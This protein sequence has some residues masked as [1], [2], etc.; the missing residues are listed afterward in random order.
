MHVT[1]NMYE[2]HWTNS[3]CV[4]GP[5]N[6]TFLTVNTLH[7]S[8]EL[9]G[10]P[11]GC[12]EWAAL[13][14]TPHPHQPSQPSQPSPA[15][16]GA[17]VC[18]LGS[19]SPLSP[20]TARTHHR[21][22]RHHRHRKWASHDDHKYIRHQIESG[23]TAA[24]HPAT[25]KATQEGTRMQCPARSSWLR[26]LQSVTKPSLVQQRSWPEQQQQWPRVTKYQW[27]PTMA[28]QCCVTR[29]HYHHQPSIHRY[30]QPPPP[31]PATAVILLSS[32]MLFVVNSCHN[33]CSADLCVSG[34]IERPNLKVWFV[35]VS[36]S[37]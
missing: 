6:P 37:S 22:H 26:I 20:S 24:Q 19:S 21:H 17:V 12:M 33:T 29:P 2:Y 32:L 28:G 18:S 30:M 23:H 7:V 9:G 3:W 14:V 1:C 4:V 13:M 35:F 11:A 27:P 31:P 5:N 16:H 15:Q 10:V 34:F 8:I 25:S 36:L